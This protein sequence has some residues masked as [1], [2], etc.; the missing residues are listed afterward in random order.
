MIRTLTFAALIVSASCGDLLSG[1]ENCV[2]AYSISPTGLLQLTPGDSILVTAARIPGCEG[3]FPVTWLSETPLVA[4]VQ[5]AGDSTALIRALAPGVTN[6]FVGN[7]S[8]SGFTT[9]RVN[10]GQ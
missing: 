3:T 2:F 6:M 1:P 4:T 10:T 9:V 5:P 7:G 8:R